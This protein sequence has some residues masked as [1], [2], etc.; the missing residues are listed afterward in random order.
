MP[1]APDLDTASLSPANIPAHVGLILDGNGRWAN[2]R[3]LPRTAGH[4]AG[5]EA[6]FDSVDGALAAGVRWLSA[7]TFSTENWT[8][9]PDEVEFLMWFNED[10]LLRR[11]DGLNDKGVRLRFIGD[12]DDPRVP[13][14]NR[15]H[16]RE[17]EE[18][19]A[20]NDRLDFV[21]AFNY[22][23]RLEI[24][25]AVRRLARQ[26]AAGELDPDAI[27]PADIAANLFIPEMP[28]PDLI[29]RTSGEQRISN[30]LLWG[31]AYAELLF[32]DKRWPDFRAQDLID[33]VVEYQSR[34]RRF[35]KA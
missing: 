33:A 27:T 3:G 29:V 15:V 12:L 30:F 4:A 23:G 10:I 17:S 21:F 9:D 18:L 5:E 22:G 16:M 1:D 2:D 11:R 8:R 35:G 31:S 26:V 13:E 24:A 14:R 19:T 32:L 25:S 34:R 28:D 6:L 20:H 7:Y